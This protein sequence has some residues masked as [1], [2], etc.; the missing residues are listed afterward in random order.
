VASTAGLHFAL[1]TENFLIQEEMSAHFNTAKDFIQTPI[2]FEAGYW[3]LKPCT[4]LGLMVDEEFVAKLAGRNEPLLTET[5]YD[6]DGA[7]VDW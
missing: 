5:A 1:A 3:T 4:G 7:I 2:H 6:P